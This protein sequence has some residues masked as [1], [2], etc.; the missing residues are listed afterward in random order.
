VEIARHI[1]AAERD[2]R[3]AVASD[4]R[5][6][7]AWIALADLLY[8]DLWELAEARLDAR[9][10]YQADAFLLERDHFAWLCEIS[11]QLKDYEEAQHW[12]A[13]G[14]RRFPERA[15][16]LLMV[17]LQLLA[18]DGVEPDVVKAWELV[19]EMQRQDSPDFNVPAAKMVTAAVLV[20]AGLPDSAQA[21]ITDARRTIPEELAP[22]LDYLEAYARLRLDQRR[23]SLKLLRSFLGV[24]PEY[25]AQLA[26]DHWFEQLAGDATFERLVDR[27]RRPIFCRLLC[28]PPDGR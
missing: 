6:A 28:E 13:E 21:I 18:T 11:F 15:T 24:A 12:C 3:R 27:Q 17:E 8:N 2:L 25:R 23:E 1:A 9:R 22:Y 14:R 20:R 4:P 26:N 16:R 5:L 19:G 10:A 7:S